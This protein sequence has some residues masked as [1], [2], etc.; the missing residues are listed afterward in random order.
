[1]QMSRWPAAPQ[2]D[3]TDGKQNKYQSKHTSQSES[4]LIVHE[5]GITNESL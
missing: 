5:A 3:S 4:K 2:F 1:M